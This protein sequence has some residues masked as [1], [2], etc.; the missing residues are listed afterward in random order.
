MR[1]TQANINEIVASTK[2]KTNVKLNDHVTS[3]FLELLTL[4]RTRAALWLYR[5]SHEAF[6]VF[7][8]IRIGTVENATPVERIKFAL[9]GYKLQKCLVC[10]IEI[11]SPRKATKTCAGSCTRLYVNGS[12]VPKAEV[13]A[14]RKQ[15]GRN[16]TLTGSECKLLRSLIATLGNSPARHRVK[17]LSAKIDSKLITIPGEYYTERIKIALNKN[18]RPVCE[19][20]AK[21][22]YYPNTMSFA[23]FCSVRCGSVSESKNAK[24]KK[25]TIA[26][27]GG[28]GFQL[29]KT[30]A[31][32][33]LKYNGNPSKDPL[34]KE[35]KRITTKKNFGVDNPSQSP[36]IQ[37]HKVKLSLLKYGY[38]NPNQHPLLA[39]KQAKSA[40]RRKLVKSG[41]RIMHLQGYEPQA[42]DYLKKN[43][44]RA[45]HIAS[46]C[47]GLVPGIKYRKKK[48]RGSVYYADFFIKKRN[49]LIEVKSTYT[50][51][52]CKSQWELNVTK[53]KA[54]KAAGFKL[55]VLVMDS[56][57]NRLR[58]PRGWGSF[59]YSEIREALKVAARRST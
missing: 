38:E 48:G 54:A 42:F 29:E 55:A 16:A 11:N 1:V 34:V 46:T 5:K 43:G 27:H 41:K 9:G 52:T 2:A 20:G 3:I 26:R 40:F 10:N 7:C 57:G 8:G 33:R 30:K 44:V 35:K 6:V 58:L 32:M 36:E 39:A 18:V 56:K 47:S 19:C 21:V 22:N 23:T 45:S 25:T 17:E 28:V 31:T 37:A 53:F 12:F 14:A 24:I 4:K 15:F 59:C 49:L 50:L 51:A 13:R